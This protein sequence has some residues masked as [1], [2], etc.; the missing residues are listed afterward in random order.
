MYIQNQRK[1][2]GEE[3]EMDEKIALRRLHVVIPEPL[4]QKLRSS[5]VIYAIDETVT[6]LLYR[7]LKELEEEKEEK[8]EEENG[9]GKTQR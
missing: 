1:K 4:F 8:G 2:G 6:D 9:R 3:K 7:R 5:E